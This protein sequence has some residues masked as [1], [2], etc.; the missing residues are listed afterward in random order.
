L[1]FELLPEKKIVLCEFIFLPAKFGKNLD[2]RK[3][4]FVFFKVGAF[5]LKWK[6]LE[7]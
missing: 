4:C 1:E 6:I 5:E 2:Y 7:Y 3:L